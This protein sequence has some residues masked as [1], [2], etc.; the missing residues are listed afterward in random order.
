LAAA[1]IP[2]KEITR[3]TFGVRVQRGPLPGAGEW[4]RAH[5][6]PG[7]TFSTTDSIV[8]LPLGI[9]WWGGVGPDRIVTRHWRAPVPL[10][11]KGHMFIQG[12]HDIVGVDAYTGREMWNRHIRD[13][14]RFPPAF[15]GGNIIADGD[16]VY[17]VTGLTCYALDAKTG[18]TVRRYTHQLT[19]EQREETQKM[20][21]LHGQLK[22]TWNQM[23]GKLELVNPSIVW[24]F[25]GMA[26]DCIIGTLGYDAANLKHNRMAIPNQS[27]YIFAYDKASGEKAW[28]IKLDET[29]MP[30]AIVS[31]EQNLYYIDRTDQWTAEVLMRRRGLESFHSKLSAVRLSDGE[32]VWTRD[33]A[34]ERK[35]L[36]LKNGVI[37]ASANFS[38]VSSN[39]TSGLSAFDATNGRK[40]WEHDRVR[41]TT[42]RGGPV[43]HIFIVGDV[44]YTPEPLD[45]RT[46]E[47]LQTQVD[48][49]TGEPTRFELS[50]Q[51]FCGAVAAC[52]N[53]IAYRSTPIGFKS[54]TDNSPCY[55]LSEKRPSCWISLLPAGGMLLSPEGQSTNCT[56]SFNYKTSSALIPVE[57]H[58]SWGIYRRGPELRQRIGSAWKGAPIIEGRP[59]NFDQLRINLNAPGD[60]YDS[61]TGRGFFAWPQAT[62]EGDGFYIVPVSGDAQ[63]E[64]FRFNSDFNPIAGTKRPWIYSSGL[65]GDIQLEVLG[66]EERQ[67]RVVL[68]FA[69]PESLGK[70]DRVFDVLINGDKVFS[71]LDIVAET[72]APKTALAKVITELAPCTT[73]KIE[74]KSVSDQPALLCGVEVVPE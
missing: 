44:V 68:H 27:R 13:V 11:S 26:G 34:P 24:E 5:G 56:C 21:P 53:M 30:T 8:K 61:E 47:P 64:G 60:H 23:D 42:R 57:R 33:L 73:V 51:Y 7:N 70:G 46:G 18:E 72:G 71:R 37:V 22:S 10:F 9:L 19:P 14:G 43:R 3:G 59:A 66:T 49:L 36:F 50:G 12:Q 16:C 1:G 32:T 58:E 41:A 67:Y 6:N 40:L 2:E 25:L 29:V 28:E 17:C 69:E 45:L 48:P 54:L 55:W 20:L 62:R 74:L 63:A 38:D 65:T 4:T 39:S 35:A 31:D 52:E 15:R